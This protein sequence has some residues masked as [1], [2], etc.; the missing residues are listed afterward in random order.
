MRWLDLT[1]KLSLQAWQASL[2]D[3]ND[4]PQRIAAGVLSFAL[5]FGAVWPWWGEAWL[6]WQAANE[7]ADLAKAQLQEAQALKKQTTQIESSVQSLHLTA[8]VQRLGASLASHGLVVGDVGMERALSDA[9]HASLQVAQVPVRVG[10]EGAWVNWQAWLQALPAHMPGTTLA[11]L[12][13]K[14][15]KAGGMTAHATLSMPRMGD[16]ESAWALA[17][18]ED[19]SRQAASPLDAQSWQAAQKAHAE[20]HAALPE[21]A[22]APNRVKDP[23][24]FFSRSQLQYVGVMGWGDVPQALVRVNDPRAMTSVYRVP[25]GGRLGKDAG[26]VRVID[27]DHLLIDEW[28]QDAAGQWRSQEVRMPLWTGAAR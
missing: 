27:S 16:D 11:A 2:L 13:I 8:D 17:S 18:V 6:S 22:S 1:S 9:R 5:G 10:F 21:H 12:D 20:Q 28:V 23:L 15:A 19:T 4:R 24:E 14:P 26:R 3:G 25:L 7:A